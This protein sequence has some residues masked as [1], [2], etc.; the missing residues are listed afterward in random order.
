[1]CIYKDYMCIYKELFRV[2]SRFTWSSTSSTDLRGLDV[3]LSLASAMSGLMLTLG[4][5]LPALPPV[6]IR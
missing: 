6:A 5:S 2:A 4:L 3:S 1:M